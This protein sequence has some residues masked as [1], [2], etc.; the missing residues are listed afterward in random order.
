[1]L[2]NRP[3]QGKHTKRLV[4]RYPKSWPTESN[5]EKLL[6]HLPNLVEIEFEDFDEYKVLHFLKRPQL[7]PSLSIC[8]FRGTQLN[9]SIV[10]C[11]SHIP[12]LRLVQIS[13]IKIKE[14][15]NCSAPARQVLHVAIDSDYHNTPPSPTVISLFFP[16]ASISSLDIT[17]SQKSYPL[18]SLFDVLDQNISFLRLRCDDRVDLRNQR[19]DHLLP[20]LTNLRY[21]HLDPPFVSNSLQT[22]LLSLSSLVTLS[23]VYTERA[24]NLDHLLSRLDSLRHL[25]RIDLAYLD[26]GKGHELDMT[27][28]ERAFEYGESYHDSN[29]LTILGEISNLCEMDGWSLP[30]SESISDVL[31]QVIEMEE[32]ARSLGL[33]VDS[34]L[35]ELIQVFQLAIL[36]C[37]NRA[38]AQ[39]YFYGR[40]DSLRYALSLA[41]KHGLDINRLE[42]NLDEDDFDREDLEWFYVRVDGDAGIEV[43]E[44][45]M[46]MGLRLRTKSID[47]DLEEEEE[48]SNGESNWG[49]EESEVD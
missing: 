35:P 5:G 8:R 41:E 13:S 29:Y 30:W 1:M 44:Y 14:G 31:P 27:H 2:D 20:K 6:R 17:I 10:D 16:T 12:T 23:L 22:H 25:R 34:N 9:T 45:C 33:I 38:V 18:L 49:S 39:L 40:K 32:K 42:I 48:E 19:I 11:L 26:V 36:E 37:Y 28:A 4:M 3:Y 47:S 7:V 43:E 15:E 24:P 46:A 21:L